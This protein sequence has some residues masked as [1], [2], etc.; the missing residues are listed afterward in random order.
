MLC[1]SFFKNKHYYNS[2][3]CRWRRGTRV[4][5]PMEETDSKINYHPISIVKKQNYKEILLLFSKARVVFYSATRA[6]RLVHNPEQFE[7]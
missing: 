7:M 5:V 2:C 1:F 3:P 4:T 6:L